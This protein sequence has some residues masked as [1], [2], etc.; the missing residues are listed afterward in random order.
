MEISIEVSGGINRYIVFNID[1]DWIFFDE[2]I[3]S[4][5]GISLLEYEQR[6]K[7][8]VFCN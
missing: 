5:L 1:D 3:S 6:F 8:N 7:N 4:V 2:S